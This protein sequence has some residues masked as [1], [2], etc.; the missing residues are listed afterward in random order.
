MGH[1]E[2]SYSNAQTPP[3]VVTSDAGSIGK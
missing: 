3:P 1:I 2:D